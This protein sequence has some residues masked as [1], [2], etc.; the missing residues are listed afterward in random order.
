M[1]VLFMCITISL[2]LI[3]NL[4]IC[5]IAPHSFR[6]KILEIPTRHLIMYI[7]LEYVFLVSYCISEIYSHLL[8]N[9]V[10]F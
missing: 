1:L 6:N 5:S 2:L 7:I 8:F 3:L 10:L 9:L 4:C